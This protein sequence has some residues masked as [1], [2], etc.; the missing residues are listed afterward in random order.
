MN[1]PNQSSANEGEPLKKQIASCIVAEE[2][3]GEYRYVRLQMAKTIR[4][5][6]PLS[7]KQPPRIIKIFRGN[8]ESKIPVGSFVMPNL[9]L[10]W[11]WARGR[12]IV[13]AE[14]LQRC[15]DFEMPVLDAIKKLIHG[16]SVIH[17]V[18]TG[19]GAETLENVEEIFL[20]AYLPSE[21]ATCQTD[22]ER[23]KGLE[24]SVLSWL[25]FESR[26]SLEKA[27]AEGQARA[28]EQLEKFP[29]NLPHESPDVDHYKNQQKVLDA[30]MRKEWPRL[31]AA[32]DKLKLAKSESERVE[33]KKQVWLAYIADYK[34]LYNTHPELRE[35]ETTDLYRDEDYLRLMAEIRNSRRGNVDKRDWQLAHGWITKNYYR[36]SETELEAAFNRDWLGAP[37][38]GAS[39]RKRA[40]RMAD[41]G[42]ITALPRGRR[43]IHKFDDS[44]L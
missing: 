35:D 14:I 28:V 1:A 26:E 19:H 40:E 27:K 3:P 32:T 41:I 30:L 34:S 23:L 7:Q 16:K 42:L 22:E 10:E 5:A 39:L 9:Q 11:P 12:Q 2:K 36:M 43:E 18:L 29:R 38:T 31:F 8:G 33:G 4:A 6:Q 15:I 37:Q 17:E 44:A 21:L 24:N 13:R 20:F 25:A